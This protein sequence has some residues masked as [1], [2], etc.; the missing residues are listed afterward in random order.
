MNTFSKRILSLIGIIT[1]I[2][3]F[4][5]SV[6]SDV[7]ITTRHGIN[8]W[9]ALFEGEILHFYEYNLNCIY[10]PQR[11]ETWSAIYNIVIYFIFA[12]WDFPLW[13]VE[14]IFGIDVLGTLGGLLWGKAIV[15]PFLVGI[16]KRIYDICILIMTEKDAS[17]TIF[18]F[19]TS[20]YVLFTVLSM[21][22]YDVILLFCILNG[23]YGYLINNNKIFFCSFWLAIPLKLFALFM[24]IPLVLLKEKSIFKIIFKL[25]GTCSLYI[26]TSGMAWILENDA[27]KEATALQ[28]DIIRKL[29]AN[30]IQLSLM[31]CSLFIMVIIVIYLLCYLT[32]RELRIDNIWIIYIVYIIYA[33]FCVL[34]PTSPQWHILMC[35][36]MMILLVYEKKNR[37]VLLILEI[38]ATS[39][40]ILAQGIYLN[41]IIAANMVDLLWIADI[42]GNI[43]CWEEYNSIYLLLAEF[44]G[45]EL[46]ALILKILVPMYTVSMILFSI[47]AIPHKLGFKKYLIE[48]TEKS[49]RYWVLLR[50]IIGIFLAIIPLLSF[51]VAKCLGR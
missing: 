13:L 23:I 29:F 26:F 33:A 10:L 18:L 6:F 16:A 32:K 11:S 17:D 48:S 47:F 7:I 51:I 38:V 8:F 30:N 4:T 12:I 41:N 27:I 14:H 46:F 49:V 45:N 44:V 34:C 25:L 36:F 42:F 24:L 1:I 3:I 40:I 21:G 28:I 19:L 31:E 43:R 39:S 2:F 15:L 9:H 50:S 20:G 37:I 35:P 22:Q 5:T